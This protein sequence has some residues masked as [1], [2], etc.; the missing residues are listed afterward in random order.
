M[1]GQTTPIQNKVRNSVRNIKKC[2]LGDEIVMLKLA[3]G[4]Q[5]R[6]VLIESLGSVD[7]SLTILLKIT[8]IQ[9]FKNK[10]V[11]Y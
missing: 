8:D 5:F 9:V 11:F 10:I 1:H 2:L 6:T 4:T 7:I 3:L